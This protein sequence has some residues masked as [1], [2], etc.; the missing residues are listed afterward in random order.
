MS[1]S[2]NNAY[3]TSS[4]RWTAITLLSCIVPVTPG[5]SHVS[6]PMST[7]DQ[8]RLRIAL[9]A[10]DNGN[11]K[12]AQPLLADLAARYPANFEA[13]EA[14]GTLYI[15]SGDVE[16][17]TPYLQR[18]V[19]LAPRQGIAHANLGAAYLKLNRN[20][21]AARELQLAAKLDPSN[22]DTQSNLG[23]ALMLTG[24]PA[25]AAK[26]FAVA[27]SANPSNSDLAYNLALAHYDSG[28][29]QQSSAALQRIPPSAMTD[30][31]HSLAGDVNEKLGDYKQAIVHYQAAARVN[32]SDANIYTLTLELL[33][34]WTWDE[35]IQIANY[36]ASRYPDKIHFKVAEGIALYGSSRYPAAASAFS[37][38][39]AQDPEN[40]LYA[41]LLGR[42][43]SLVADG[44]NPDCNGL[45]DFAR[46]HPENARAATYAAASILHRPATE[47]DTAKAEQMLRQAIVAD[48]KLADAY[49]QLGVLQQQRSQ[50]KE[51]SVSLEEAVA[52]RPTSAE[53]HYR[54]SRAY[55]HLGMRDEAQQQMALQRKYSQQ[56]KDHL[57]SRMQEVVT[58]LLKPS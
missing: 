5:Q 58:F 6:R 8:A 20:S 46:R 37:K 27:S 49:Y 50:W 21:E 12:V 51:S 32:P 13:T 57:D 55:A 29:L 42:T 41:D 10:Y 48:P 44:V 26:A 52:L 45:E 15:E 40:I 34:H 24:Q 36:G 31:A 56:Q 53:A 22:A 25:L 47:Q 11:S 18:A 16:K 30:Q 38:L 39:L 33:R 28:S 23:N 19:T 3:C 9:D 54:L 17:A 43:C 14:L 7:G 2:H 35:A 4:L 1:R